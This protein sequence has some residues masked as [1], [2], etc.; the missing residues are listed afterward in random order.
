MKVSKISK[1]DQIIVNPIP[2]KEQ[3]LLYYD[4]I[5]IP[6][7]IASKSFSIWISRKRFLQLKIFVEKLTINIFRL[8]PKL[9]TKNPSKFRRLFVKKIFKIYIF[10]TKSNPGFKV[11]FPGVQFTGQ[12]S[13]P[14]AFTYCAA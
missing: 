2:G 6:I 13:P 9:E 12:T 1:F 7:K 3:S 14:F 4:R 5:Q 11:S 8:K 10:P